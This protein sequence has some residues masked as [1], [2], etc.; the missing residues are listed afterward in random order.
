MK[1]LGAFLGKTPEPILVMRGFVGMELKDGKDS[2]V[3]KSVLP[4][5]PAA[6]AGLKTGDKIE[7]IQGKPVATAAEIHRL[8][9]YLK[10]GQTLQFKITRGSEPQVLSI[11]LGEGF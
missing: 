1:L 7:E 9:T 2:V 8:A 11:T 6:R 4:S 10:E 3:I 5:G